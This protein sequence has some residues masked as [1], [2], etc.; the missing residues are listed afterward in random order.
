MHTLIQK[1]TIHIQAIDWYTTYW[2]IL[3]LGLGGTEKNSVIILESV[4]TSIFKETDMIINDMFRSNHIIPFLQDG[5]VT[6]SQ[7]LIARY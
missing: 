6:G 4:R 1:V 2:N 7:I 3:R 5:N